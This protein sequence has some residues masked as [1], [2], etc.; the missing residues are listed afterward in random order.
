MLMRRTT[1][2]CVVLLGM[3]SEHDRH[4]RHGMVDT[5]GA[6]DFGSGHSGV[7]RRETAQQ[8][9]Q[10]QHLRQAGRLGACRAL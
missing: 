9:E 8:H 4:H 6:A 3:F 2:M 1:F 7:H 10:A 5:I